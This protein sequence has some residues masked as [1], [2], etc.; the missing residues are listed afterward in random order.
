MSDAADKA[1][2]NEERAMEI[3]QRTRPRFE[4]SPQAFPG[5]GINC[6]DCGEIILEARL[7]AMPRT[8]RCATC[9]AEVE[10]KWNN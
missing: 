8:L 1:A 7:R 5:A 6:L 3:F 9:A 2:E 10:R 4:A